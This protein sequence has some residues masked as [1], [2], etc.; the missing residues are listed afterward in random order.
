MNKVLLERHGGFM[1]VP[2]IR[3]YGLRFRIFEVV[4][5]VTRTLGA[6]YIHI[7]W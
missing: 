7:A 4:M 6:K 3:G 2:D 5:N 1:L